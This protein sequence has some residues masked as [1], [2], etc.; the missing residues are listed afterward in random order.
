M[1]ERWDLCIVITK[2]MVIGCSEVGYDVVI[3]VDK[4]YRSYRIRD[5]RNMILESHNIY[6]LQNVQ[7]RL[8]I[9]SCH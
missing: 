1:V 8:F 7:N 6:T 4:I 3:F 2:C 9:I 5:Q